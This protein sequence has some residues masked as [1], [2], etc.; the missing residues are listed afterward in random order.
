MVSNK[1]T[2]QMPKYSAPLPVNRSCSGARDDDAGGGESV[3]DTLSMDSIP[4]E[5]PRRFDSQPSTAKAIGG[6][7]PWG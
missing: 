3:P 1:L 5:W 4:F 7:V 6:A 2:I